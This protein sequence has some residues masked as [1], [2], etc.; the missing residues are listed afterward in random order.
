[1]RAF[2]NFAEEVLH[3]LKSETLSA[4]QRQGID[5]AND[6]EGQEDSKKLSIEHGERFFQTLEVAL[7]ANRNKAGQSGRN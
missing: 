6:V 5:P 7:S 3:D 1:V 2:P 4:L